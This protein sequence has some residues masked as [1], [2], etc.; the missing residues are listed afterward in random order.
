MYTAEYIKASKAQHVGEDLAE[1]IK[2]MDGLQAKMA[3]HEEERAVAFA[4]LDNAVDL[5]TAV[6]KEGA[7]HTRLMALIVERMGEMI[8]KN[9]RSAERRKAE[10]SA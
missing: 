6:G 8:H 5:V 10:M 2:Q 3:R 9:S 7:Q 4:A 1:A